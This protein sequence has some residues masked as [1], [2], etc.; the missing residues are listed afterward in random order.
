M[1]DLAEVTAL[2]ERALPGSRATVSDLGGGD[3]LSVSVVAPQFAGL[4]LVAQHQLIHAALKSKM[5]PVSQEIHALQIKTAATR[6]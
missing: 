3:H 2:I 4:G 1:A 6:D 5:P